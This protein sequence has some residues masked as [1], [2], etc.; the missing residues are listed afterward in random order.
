MDFVDRISEI[1]KRISKQKDNIH[2]EEATKTAL[3]MPLIQALGYDVFNPTEVVPEFVADIGTKK[4]EKVDY[5]IKKDDKM[6]MLIECKWCGCDLDQEHA[7]QLYRYFAV[8]DARFGILTNGV[9]YKF[10]SDIEE[11]NKMDLK[12]FFEFDLLDMNDQNI[13]EL[14]KF[15]KPSFDLDK[16]ITTASELK[17]INSIKRMFSEEISNPTNEFIKFFGSRIYSG[18][19]TKRVCEQFGKVVKKALLQFISEKVSDRLKMALEDEKE[20]TAELESEIAND[21]AKDDGIVTTEEEIE[22]YNI[23]KAIVREIVDVK[24]VFMRDTKSYCGILLDNNNRKPICR[25]RFNLPQK[26]IVMF[27]QKNRER[28]PID[29]LN[30]IFK[31]ADRLKATVLDYIKPHS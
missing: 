11:A 12:P 13:E 24:R 5:A 16:I 7:S 10:Y 30:D 20:E 23:V 6:V 29:N 28:V 21:L 15:A 19:M 2:N 27:K 18:K 17:Y 25:L 8:T 22:G 14:K 26:H 9:H 3:V 31:Y 4:G 1:S